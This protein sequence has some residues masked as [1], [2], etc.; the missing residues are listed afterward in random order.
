MAASDDEPWIR[1]RRIQHSD[2]GAKR[3][4]TLVSEVM[5]AAKRVG[6]TGKSFNCTSARNWRSTGSRA[7]D[8]NGVAP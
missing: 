1:H 4:K 2:R 5:R 6:H 3:L 7:K 8:W